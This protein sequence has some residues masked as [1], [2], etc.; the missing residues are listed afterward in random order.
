MYFDPHKP[1]L[2]L[3]NMNNNRRKKQLILSSVL[4]FVFVVLNIGCQ[5]E[6]EQ[7]P[8]ASSSNKFSA[9]MVPDTNLDVYVYAQQKSLTSIP[10]GLINMPNNVD[11]ESLAMWGVPEDEKLVLGMCLTLANTTIAAEV[12]PKII[13]D[14]QIWKLLR[15]NRIYLVRGSGS[16]AE[17]MKTTI[18]NNNFK[19][20]TDR[21]VLETIATMP[22]RGSVTLAAIAVVKPSKA[23]INTISEIKGISY[24]DQIIKLTKLLNPDVVV[25]GLYSPH[26]I[27]IARAI[28]VMETKGISALDVG[29]LVLVKSGLPSFVQNSVAKSVLAGQGFVGKSS[30]GFLLYEGSVTTPDRKSVP[31]LIRIEDSYIFAA[32]A[33][34]TAYAETL[35][36]GIYK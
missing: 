2:Y 8:Y 11:V 31:V 3:E 13:L 22:N 26:Q 33:G 15:D 34:Q 35:I 4:V 7:F 10:A 5:W 32:A 16:S 19:Y 30:N 21:K 28:D 17:S 1:I 12:Y 36:T 18:V 14:G 9:F 24:I 23:V 6:A 25:C 20:Y 29:T 27:N